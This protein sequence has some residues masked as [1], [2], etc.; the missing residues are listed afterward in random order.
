MSAF[1]EKRPADRVGVR[2]RAA[3]G[4]SSEYLWGPN[5]Q[6]C[7]GCGARWLPSEFRFCGVCGQALAA[8]PVGTVAAGQASGNGR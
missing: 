5:K 4:G 7:P 8:E 3:E 2:R 6:S 1:V